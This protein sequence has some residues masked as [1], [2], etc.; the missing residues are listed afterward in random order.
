[1]NDVLEIL[2]FAFVMTVITMI[3]LKLWSVII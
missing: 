2:T 1:M 3:M